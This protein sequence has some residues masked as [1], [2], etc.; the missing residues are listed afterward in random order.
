MKHGAVV[1][2]NGTFNFTN[3]DALVTA[4]GSMNIFGHTLNWHQN[5]NATYLKNYSGITVP[6]ATENLGNPD[7][8][9]GLTGWS[10]FNSGN[11]AGTSTITTT[12]VAGETHGGT[13]AMKVIN[14]IGYPGSQWRVQIA[15]IL[16][17]TTPGAQYTFSYWVKAASAG[18]SIRL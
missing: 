16:V 14:P 9:Q 8:E 15:S 12:N 5:N 6:S 17:N 13:T 1:Q 2:D 18:G 3:T 7:F 4:V 11:P 10:I